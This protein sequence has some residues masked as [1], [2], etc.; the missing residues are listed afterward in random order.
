MGVLFLSF[1]HSL[2]AGCIDPRANYDEFA[3]RPAA[4][5]PESDAAAVDVPLTACESLLQQPLS[6]KYFTSCMVKATGLPFALAIDLSVTGI[7][8]GMP[9]V[10]ISFTPLRIDAV[11]IKDTVGVYTAL[12]KTAVKADCSYDQDLGELVIP[13]EA[14]TIGTK[15]TAK[16]V[17]LHG[18]LQNVEQNCAELDGRTELPIPLSLAGLGDSCLFTRIADDGPIVRPDPSEYQCPRSDPAP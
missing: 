13:A 10:Q 4:T 18:L 12:P 9:E 8:A 6:G 15:V 2:F 1:V 3:A 11:T 14:T 5:A 17:T 7:D 16:D